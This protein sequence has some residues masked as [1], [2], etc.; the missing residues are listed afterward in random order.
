MWTIGHISI[1]YIIGRPFYGKGPAKPLS[2][3]LIFFTA[4]ILDFA[5][6]YAF[7]TMTHSM[8]FFIIFLSS[9]LFV[10]FN[11]HIIEKKDIVPLV[12]AGSSHILADVLFGSFYPFLPFSSYKISIFS[13]GSYLDYIIEIALFVIMM[14]ALTLSGDLSNLKNVQPLKKIEKRFQKI[15]HNLVIFGLIFIILAEAGGVFYLDFLNGPN[16]YNQ[17][18]YND[19]SMWYISLAF[20]VIQVLFVFIL[21]QWAH[22]RLTRKKVDYNGP[23]YHRHR[24]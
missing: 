9:I 8:V 11:L 24:F 5:H 17:S 10:L 2:L 22:D 3:V 13:W 12:A 15:F 1:G 21:L 14:I 19:G 23:F 20:I 6:V 18:V 7:R 16:F 4:V